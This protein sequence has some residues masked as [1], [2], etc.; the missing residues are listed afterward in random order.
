MSLEQSMDIMELP[1][2]QRELSSGAANYLD[3]VYQLSNDD[4]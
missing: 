2:D 3:L 4:G 1:A